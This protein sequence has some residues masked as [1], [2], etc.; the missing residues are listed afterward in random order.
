MSLHV[1]Q[2]FLLEAGRSSGCRLICRASTVCFWVVYQLNW[3]LLSLSCF[4]VGPNR[5]KWFICLDFPCF[6]FE[7]ARWV[8][9]RTR[10]RWSNLLE[11]YC[12][13]FASFRYEI[14]REYTVSTGVVKLWLTF[15]L[16][17]VEFGN[18]STLVIESRLL[19]GFP[20]ERLVC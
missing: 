16:S 2:A 18:F 6:Q 10:L 9:P 11:C 8:P 4:H 12:S 20:K 1:S 5:F 17:Y 7:L 19:M 3:L 13:Q 15:E 14:F